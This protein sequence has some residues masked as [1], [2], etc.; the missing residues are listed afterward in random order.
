MTG[1]TA[2]SYGLF[3]MAELAFCHGKDMLWPTTSEL[4][5]QMAGSSTHLLSTDLTYARA[6]K[7]VLGANSGQAMFSSGQG[8]SEKFMG[9]WLSATVYL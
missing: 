8:G 1:L 3:T 9:D 2:Q 4:L 5:V 6:G 7:V